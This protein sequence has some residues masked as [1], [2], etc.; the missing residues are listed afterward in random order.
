MMLCYLRGCL[1]VK[2][3]SSEVGRDDGGFASC[4]KRLCIRLQVFMTLLQTLSYMILR[5]ELWSFGSME[6]HG[7]VGNRSS[8]DLM[9][10]GLLGHLE[11]QLTT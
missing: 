3:T 5:K 2:V 4:R 1:L 6:R 7:R 11:K 8:R 10:M 9:V